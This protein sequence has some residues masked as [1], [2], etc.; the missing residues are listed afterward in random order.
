MDMADHDIPT[1]SSPRKPATLSERGGLYPLAGGEP[2]L[3]PGCC[4]RTSRLPGSQTDDRSMCV[5]TTQLQ[6]LL[7]ASACDR[8][9]GTDHD[10][11]S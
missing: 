4:Q 5:T 6:R 1:S 10:F 9:A 2:R 8:E 3:I 11:G 7:P